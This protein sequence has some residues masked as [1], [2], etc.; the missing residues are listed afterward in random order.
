MRC[1]HAGS[2]SVIDKDT[3]AAE[4]CPMGKV[5]SKLLSKSMMGLTK[6]S[7]FADRRQ[8]CR[9]RPA[10]VPSNFKQWWF[11][12]SWLCSPSPNW[13]LLI[14]SACRD[15]RSSSCRGCY[16]RSQVWP[17]LVVQ[18]CCVTLSHVH[19]Y[20]SCDCMTSWCDMWPT[21]CSSNVSPRLTATALQLLC[22]AA[23]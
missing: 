17:L 14:Y 6:L 22:C 21:C 5:A 20:D 18:Q 16:K 3:T 13:L 9:Q 11:A 8:H 15:T 12:S 4:P 7:C 19:G 10:L 23:L 2:R 1:V